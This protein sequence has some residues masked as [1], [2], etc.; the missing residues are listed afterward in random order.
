MTPA[1]ALDLL[2]SGEPFEP[3]RSSATF[4]E[5]VSDEGMTRS[6]RIPHEDGA[7]RSGFSP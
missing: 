1:G 4:R 6:S 3:T 7:W 2:D 5:D